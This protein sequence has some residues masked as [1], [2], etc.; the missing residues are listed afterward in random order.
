VV[1]GDGCQ[2]MKIAIVSYRYSIEVSPIIKNLAS[3]FAERGHQ[4][5]I[6]VDELYR[7]PSFRMP[8]NNIQVVNAKVPMQVN[9]RLIYKFFPRY[10]DKNKGREKEF[11]RR[12]EKEINYFAIIIAVDFIV[13]DL[14]RRAN[15]CLDNVIVLLL[16]GFNYCRQYKLGYIK[17]L[18]D[19]CKMI[20]FSDEARENDFCKLLG[21]ELKNIDYLPVS[22]RQKD[23]RRKNGNAK[24]SVDL[25]YS[26]YF[27]EWACV[28]EIINLFKS[29]KNNAV[30]LTLNGHSMGTDVYLQEA[31]NSSSGHLGIFFDQNY[32]DDSEYFDYLS[33]YDIGIALYKDIFNDGNFFNII[34][35]SGKIANYLCS[36]LAVLTNIENEITAN[37]PFLVI[38][39]F[40]DKAF[41]ESIEYFINNKSIYANSAYELAYG[42]YNFDDYMNK[43]VSKWIG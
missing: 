3:Y 14:L 4:I 20:L 13:V 41:M 11:K 19:S 7:H 24:F 16:E 39:D 21:F 17:K 38:K 36:G 30:T 1:R 33:K 32:Y 34:R 42:M 18:L 2:K 6:F 28:H 25:L 29:C 26:G 5:T 43:I 9:G 40:S 8:D 37:P 35:S 31:V 27:A 22:C 10:F 15:I 23:I 12:I